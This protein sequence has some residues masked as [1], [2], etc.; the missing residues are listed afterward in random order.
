L[1]LGRASDAKKS[2]EGAQEVLEQLIPGEE[3][4]RSTARRYLKKVKELMQK[5]KKE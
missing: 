1:R 4:R 3:N 5:I 2:L